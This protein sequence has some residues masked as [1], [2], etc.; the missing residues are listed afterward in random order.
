VAKAAHYHLDLKPAAGQLYFQ[1]VAGVQDKPGLEALTADCEMVRGTVTVRGKVTDKA[2]GKPVAGAQV[3]YR[4]FY[5]N[6]T[7][8]QMDVHSWPHGGATTGADGTYALPVMPGPGRILVASP[9]PDAYMPA[10]SSREER[11]AFF[12]T[13]GMEPGFPEEGTIAISGGGAT[14]GA[15][16]Q[17]GYHAVVLLEPGE[18]E[19]ALV[20]HVALERPQERKGQVVGPDGKPVTGVTV[21][22]LTPGAEET[23]KGAEFTVRGINPKMPARVLTF[24]HKGKGLASFLKELP[25]EK[26][27]S[28]LVK[29]QPC[30]SLS[31]RIVDKD[32][33][34]VVGLHGQLVPGFLKGEKFTTDK[35]GRYRVEGLV[36]GLRYSIGWEIKDGRLVVSVQDKDG[37]VVES[38]KNKNLS[39]FQ[40]AE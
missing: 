12:K 10:W 15:F 33:Q 30:G 4:P 40:V 29:L 24:H 17:E 22:G 25:A 14:L 3:V 13:R 5:G 27:G 16:G 19:E 8:A 21:R 35:E 38:G 2:T 26:D 11:K 18:K 7:A 9:R 20:R 34:P 23:L 1:R 32:G 37:A 6:E 36:P 31:G 39:D 28:L